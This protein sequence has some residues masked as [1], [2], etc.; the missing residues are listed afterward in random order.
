MNTP[1]SR[2]RRGFFELD[3]LTTHRPEAPFPAVRDNLVSDAPS[4]IDHPRTERPDW[5][6]RKPR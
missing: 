1:S 6:P 2:T 4:G 5:L 3:R